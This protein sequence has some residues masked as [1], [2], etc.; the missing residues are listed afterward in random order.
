MMRVMTPIKPCSR[1][2]LLTLPLALLACASA[3]STPEPAHDIRG[4]GQPTVVLASGYAM[5]RSTWQPVVDALAP[6][7][8]V[9]A[10]DRPGHG[11]QPDTDRPRDPCSMATELRQSLQAAGLPP[12]YLLVGH[13]LGGLHQ[14]AFARLY[15][16][17]V[18]GLVLLD[19]THPR[20]W[21]TLQDRHPLLATA[22]KGM[23]AL[24]PRQALRQEF[25][26]QTEC[27]DRFPRAAPQATQA[28]V[29]APVHLLFSRRYR[30]MEQDFAP[31]LQA[32]QADWPTLTGPATTRVL[33]D[34]G[35]H[36]QQE[37][38]DA[39]GQ[40]VRAVARRPLPAAPGP[41]RVAVG[42]S[43]DQWVDLGSTRQNDVASRLGPPDETHHD[44]DRTVW[45]YRAPGVRVPMAVSLIPV[46]GDLA[47]LLEMAQGA[48]ERFET[49][50]TF[51]AQ[52]VVQHARRRAVED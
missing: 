2:L 1:W 41:M 30:V 27:L 6:D 18:S 12:P 42:A 51:D 11:S 28:Q 16:Q 19:P 52:G 34:S 10:F 48:V 22:L 33:W 3:P 38:P 47:D 49:I 20:N 43:G 26:Q 24:Q 23:V 40:A 45:V 13:S 35:H 46:V 8:T 44:G 7:F 29:R 50:V 15:P 36:I 17:D 31:D 9:Y 14:F 39:V 32:L 25:R 5:P 21:A 37:R 4:S